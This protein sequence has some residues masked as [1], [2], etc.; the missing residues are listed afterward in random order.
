[1]RNMGE[2]ELP[3][4]LLA[5]ASSV[6]EAVWSSAV[7]LDGSVEAITSLDEAVWNSSTSLDEAVWKK[8]V[9]NAST[10]LDEAVWSCSS[11]LDELGKTVCNYSRGL[12]IFYVPFSLRYKRKT[13][14]VWIVFSK[15]VYLS[16]IY[17][18]MCQNIPR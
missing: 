9:W 17:A 12:G 4:A 15:D 7:S 5:W 18:S 13:I 3:V 11:L 6:D 10:S 16:Q 14:L 2:A 1:M 8:A